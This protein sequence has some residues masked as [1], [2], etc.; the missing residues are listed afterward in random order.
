MTKTEIGLGTENVI[1]TDTHSSSLSYVAGSAKLMW[2]QNVYVNYIHANRNEGEAGWLTDPTVTENG[3]TI[4]KLDL[5]KLTQKYNGQNCVYKLYYQMEIDES[6]ITSSDG[7]VLS[8]SVVVKANG[9]EAAGDA[10]FDYVYKKP[11]FTKEENSKP[12]ASNGYQAGFKITVKYTDD[13]KN[14]DGC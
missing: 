12:S 7:K 9:Q 3:T 11:L 8:N 14:S 10:S 4:L 2:A 6:L 13:Y 5:G 1:I